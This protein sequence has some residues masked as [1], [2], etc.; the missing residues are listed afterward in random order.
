M[1]RKLNILAYALSLISISEVDSHP[2]HSN[3]GQPSPTTKTKE[4]AINTIEKILEKIKSKQKYFL[5]HRLL[6]EENNMNIKRPFITLSYAQTLNGIIASVEKAADTGTLTSS[7][8]PIS[9]TESFQMTHALRTIHDGILI[10]GNTWSI[11]NPRLNV[12]LWNTNETTVDGEQKQPRPIILDSRLRH[13]HKFLGR[14]LNNEK[15]TVRCKN[16]IVC[17]SK[18]AFEEY[19]R[20]CESEENMDKINIF[21]SEHNISILP[22]ST[23][24]ENP[25]S[26]SLNLRTV[27]ERLYSIYGIKSI[28]VE[29]G[30][31][32][33]SS[34]ALD[35]TEL[36]DCL[37]VTI[38][39]KIIDSQKGLNVFYGSKKEVMCDSRITNL[40]SEEPRFNNMEYFI[41]GR[42][43][44]LL[45]S[46]PEFC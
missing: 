13:F 12:R 45:C 7:N 11:D 26:A 14:S 16:A 37:C 33:L 28:M 35:A 22:C 4:N 31:S 3:S 27:L 9:G 15:D 32:V 42:D 1:G 2:I 34:F 5:D 44:I 29:G 24:G 17:C 30:S 10:G 18:T 36:V 23:D 40:A 20:L 39:P 41:L 6:H 8:L 21:I 19:K 25:E 38:A 46:W 43:C